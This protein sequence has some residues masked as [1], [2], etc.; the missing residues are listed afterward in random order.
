[1]KSF[2]IHTLLFTVSVLSLN[3]QIAE[4][5]FEIHQDHLFIKVKDGNGVERDFMFDTGAEPS[6]FDA[7]LAKKTGMKVDGKIE[8]TG[9]DAKRSLEYVSNQSLTVADNFTLKNLHFILSDLSAFEKKFDGAIGY[10]LLEKYVTKIDYIHQKLSFYKKIKD[11]DISDY[12]AIPFKFDNDTNIPQFEI[13]IVLKNN[14]TLTTRVLFD[15]GAGLTLRVGKQFATTNDLFEKFGKT[16]TLSGRGLHTSSEYKQAVIQSIKIGTSSLG[17]MAAQVSMSDSGVFGNGT[18]LGILGNVIIS[19]FDVILDYR[20]KML[21]LK[22]NSNFEN[23][24]E[25]S[26]SGIELKKDND[27]VTVS[28]IAIES[29]AYN[30]GLRKGDKIISIN[31]DN[32]KDIKVYR[33]MLEEEGKKVEIIFFHQEEGAIKQ[34]DFLLEQ[35]L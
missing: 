12:Q 11:I 13:S 32:S 27:E 21:Y 19:R 7:G 28:N 6:L 26:R 18:H 31:K 8:V 5:P 23:A 24:F 2:F 9:A 34:V 17:E 33:R 25:F 22:A 14:E 20:K 10:D 15:S 35:L 4:L 30:L 1:M 16:I 29:A 3:A